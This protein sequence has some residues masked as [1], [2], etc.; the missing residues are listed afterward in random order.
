VKVFITVEDETKVIDCLELDLGAWRGLLAAA[1]ELR[2]R[3][4]ALNKSIRALIDLGRNKYIVYCHNKT[5][6]NLV[7]VISVIKQ[8]EQMNY[9]VQIGP[10]DA[11]SARRKDNDAVA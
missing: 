8:L 4:A 7:E 3:E 5:Q 9:E 6:T 1:D 11:F 2:S 10:A